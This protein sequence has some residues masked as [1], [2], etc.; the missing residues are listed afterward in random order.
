[1]LKRTLEENT[2]EEINIVPKKPNWDLKNQISGKMAK[3]NRKTQ[4]AIVDML[5]DKIENSI[6]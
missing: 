2:T 4:R 1:M 3:L 6:D 5:R